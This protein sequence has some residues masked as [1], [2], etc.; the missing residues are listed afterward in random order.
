MLRRLTILT[1][2]VLLSASAGA[3][4]PMPVESEW[5]VTVEANF[6]GLLDP[7]GLNGTLQ[8]AMKF[9]LRKP[10]T[11]TLYVT[12][13]FENPQDKETPLFAEFEVAPGT[14]EFTA[15]S[16]PIHAIRAR[17]KYLV[18]VWIYADVKRKQLLGTHEQPMEFN[19]PRQ[20][21]ERYGITVL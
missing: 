4:P 14:T 9:R 1:A 10:V 3:K 18:K 2:C 8:Y 19:V 7:K 20:L 11:E 13:D 15:E 12:V 6:P 16:E 5:L 17:A 21:L